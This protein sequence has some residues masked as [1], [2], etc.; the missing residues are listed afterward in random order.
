[1]GSRKTRWGMLL[2]GGN[3]C[4]WFDWLM[5]HYHFHL[6][7]GKRGARGPALDVQHVRATCKYPWWGRILISARE[8]WLNSETGLQPNS[9]HLACPRELNLNFFSS[10]PSNNQHAHGIQFPV[11]NILCW[12]FFLFLKLRKGSQRFTI[13]NNYNCVTS[14]ISE[15]NCEIYFISLVKWKINVRDNL[16]WPPITLDY[17]EATTNCRTEFNWVYNFFVFD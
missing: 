15:S 14:G 10:F 8:R 3:R 12:L 1:M 4:E 6:I 5:Y 9:S 16:S 2:K 7:G 13:I 11:F 17:R